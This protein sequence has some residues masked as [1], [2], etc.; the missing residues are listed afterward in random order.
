MT[1]GRSFERRRP[2]SMTDG[3]VVVLLRRV[4]ETQE[5]DRVLVLVVWKLNR[6]LKL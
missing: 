1:G 6:E 3:A 5:R 4:R 2:G